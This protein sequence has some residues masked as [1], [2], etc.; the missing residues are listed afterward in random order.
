M[1]PFDKKKSGISQGKYLSVHILERIVDPDDLAKLLQ[2]YAEEPKRRGSSP[3]RPNEEELKLL[4]GYVRGKVR[5]R[6][7]A[8]ALKISRQRVGQYMR[9]IAY[10]KYYY[11]TLE[12]GGEDEPDD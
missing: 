1:M 3:Q 12:R 4:D 5:G 9:G 6:E 7:L 8:S 10:A 11:D 2:R